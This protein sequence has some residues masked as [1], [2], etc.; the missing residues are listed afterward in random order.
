MSQHVVFLPLHLHAEH[1]V[2][3]VRGTL[4]LKKGGAAAQQVLHVN[5]TI[6]DL[7]EVLYLFFHFEKLTRGLG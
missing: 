6:A 3:G 5:K 4:Q 1:T 7:L 2:N